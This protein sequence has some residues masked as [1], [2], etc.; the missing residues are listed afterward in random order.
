MSSILILISQNMN[1]YYYII[2][3]LYLFTAL[4]TLIFAI[5]RKPAVNKKSY[6]LVIGG[7]LI[8]ILSDS[9]T[10]LKS[11]YYSG[12]AYEEITIMLFYGISQYLIISGLVNETKNLMEL[13]TSGSMEKL[14]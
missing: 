13:D 5:L 12:I 3:L 11:F 1:T 8:S 6:Y 2:S 14:K 7:V 9:I 10:G 4:T